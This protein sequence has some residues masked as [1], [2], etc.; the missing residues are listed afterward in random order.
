[1]NDSFSTPVNLPASDSVTHADAGRNA[2][3]LSDESLAQRLQNGDRTAFDEIVRRYQGRLFAI[4]YRIIGNREDAL[5]VTQDVFLKTYRQIS[6]WKPT[7]KFGAWLTRLTV[8]RA[9]DGARQRRR[10]PMISLDQEVPPVVQA[11]DDSSAGARGAEI[12]VRVQAALQK[13]SA[14]QRTVFVLRHYE[15]HS[16]AEIAPILGCTI[17]SVK[18]H[19]FRAMSKVRAE[20]NDLRG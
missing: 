20:L 10:R 12:E 16:L 1:M 15:G 3:R 17:G 14:M 6:D 7:G 8:N 13:L 4:A 9:I 18:V 2:H 5:D 11:P 19:L